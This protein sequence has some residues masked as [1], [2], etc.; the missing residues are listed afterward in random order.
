MSW[1][2]EVLGFT[3]L[4]CKG[5]TLNLEEYWQLTAAMVMQDYSEC[6]LT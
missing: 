4:R 6:F 3:A 2:W 5:P 1:Q